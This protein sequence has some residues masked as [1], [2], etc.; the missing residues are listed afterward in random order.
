MDDL[1]DNITREIESS[2]FPL[3]IKVSKQLNSLGWFVISNASYANEGEEL[4]REID[5]VA[6]RKDA[7]LNPLVNVLL[8]E[9]KKSSKK[10][11][12]FFKQNKIS[13][14]VFN[15][16][17]AAKAQ[18]PVYRVFEKIAPKH[19]YSTTPICTYHFVASAKKDSKES[20]AIHHAVA[21]VMNALN[22]YLNREN[23]YIE[24]YNRGEV[25][26]F[27]PIIVFDGELFS[28]IVEE[29][30]IQ[31]AEE[32]HVQLYVSRELSHA[33]EVLWDVKTK[34]KRLVKTKP[35]I[36]NIVKKGYLEKF[37]ENFS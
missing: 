9:C 23:E 26:L 15:F 14:D 3:E 30:S 2:G 27:Y 31:L 16:N 32:N 13:T 29:E 5:V 18:G 24:T 17:I 37:L 33:A 36:I 6:R 12:V 1:R 10:P 34:S 25:V 7:K 8:I 22:F 20:K 19:F 21:Q 4:R 28:A 35:F 11:W